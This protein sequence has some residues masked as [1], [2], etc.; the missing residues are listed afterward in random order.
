MFNSSGLFLDRPPS[1]QRFMPV[2]NLIVTRAW[3]DA[4]DG[5]FRGSRLQE[6]SVPTL[7]ETK[8]V[9]GLVNILA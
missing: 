5:K 8:L 2:G 3:A 1:S 4:G 7:D 6:K 9:H